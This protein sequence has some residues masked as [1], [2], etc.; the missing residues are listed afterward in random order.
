MR[1]RDRVGHFA[2]VV[3]DDT[4]CVRTGLSETLAEDGQWLRNRGRNGPV[5][6]IEPTLVAWDETRV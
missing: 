1:I 4:H 5:S 2:A 3:R 6:G